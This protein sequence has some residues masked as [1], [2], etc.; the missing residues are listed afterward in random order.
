MI[1]RV[2]STY[3]ELN[4]ILSDAQEGFRPNKNAHK[5]ILNLIHDIQDAS[6]HH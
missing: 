2:L 3:S 4:Y 6:H 1:T 5:H